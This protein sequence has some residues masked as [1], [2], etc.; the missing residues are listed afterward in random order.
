MIKAVTR[1]ALV[2]VGTGMA[3]GKLAEEVISRAPDRFQIRM[4]G[5]DPSNLEGRV[6]LSG[7]LNGFDSPEQLPLRPAQWFEERGI[8]VH[9]GI[10]A[11]QIDRNQR[12]V[13][14]GGGKVIEPYDLLVLATGSRPAVQPLPG[15]DLQGVFVLRTLDDWLAAGA[16]A[17]ESERA[18]IIGGGR[19]GLLAE[20]ALAK[21][22]L[23]VA[24]VENAMRLVGEGRVQGVELPSGMVVEADMVVM[25]GGDR[26]NIDTAQLAGLDTEC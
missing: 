7:V 26:P 3:G 10:K 8:F 2:S 21:L 11:E 9:A 14:G 6:L 12:L 17:R 22:G 23:D 25:A 15:A 20:R 19:L 4:F 16:C 5:A 1:P 13:V 24:I 18:V